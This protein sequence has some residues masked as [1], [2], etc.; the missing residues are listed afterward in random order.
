MNMNNSNIYYPQDT[1]EPNYNDL[2]NSNV[3]M[4]NTAFLNKQEE[5]DMDIFPKYPN[6]MEGENNNFD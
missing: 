5:D 4:T 6:P 3:N 2:T 1:K